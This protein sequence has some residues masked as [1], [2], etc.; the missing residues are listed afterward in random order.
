MI[1]KINNLL[2]NHA[3]RDQAF[4]LLFKYLPECDLDALNER[5]LVWLNTTI[6]ACAQKSMSESTAK[7]FDVIRNTINFKL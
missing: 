4:V 3:T 7:G 2:N 5:G 1:A 6:K